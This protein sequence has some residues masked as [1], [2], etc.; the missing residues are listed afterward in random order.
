MPRKPWVP[1]PDEA[2]F[3][4]HIYIDESSQNDHDFMVLGGIVVPLAFAQQ[5]EEAIDQSKPNNLRGIGKD[6]LPREVGWKTI[7]NG[8]FNRYKAIID[9]YG[10]FGRRLEGTKNAGMMG[11]FYSV[12]DL[13]VHGRTFSA[14]S[15]GSLAFERQMY[16]H[17]VGIAKRGKHN[18]WHIYPDDRP[19]KKTKHYELST[20]MSRGM[21]KAGC[22]KVW[23]A[24]RLNYRD[25][26][27]VQAIQ[28]S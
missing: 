9:S 15:R 25:S 10:S 5:L 28:V 1:S 27:D 21:V 2:R 19:S 3:F 20:I 17:C 14:S 13:R 4:H 12:V 7:S 26:R 23:P 22:T 8:N 18:L 11:L 16:R 6:G 24:R